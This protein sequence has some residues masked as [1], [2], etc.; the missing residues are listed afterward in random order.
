MATQR[1]LVSHSSGTRAGRRGGFSVPGRSCVGAGWAGRLRPHAARSA[2]AP[3]APARW[4][5]A[6]DPPSPRAPLRAAAAATRCQGERRH[7]EAGRAGG[8]LDGSVHGTAGLHLRACCT[9][10]SW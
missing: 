3:A 1:T 10:D 8:W 6:C 7:A 9:A 4:P 2:R 5:R